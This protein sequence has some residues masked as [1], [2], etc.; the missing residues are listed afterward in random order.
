MVFAFDEDFIRRELLFRCWDHVS[1]EFCGIWVPKY[2]GSTEF[3]KER[4]L[5]MVQRF[6]ETNRR[7]KIISSEL[8]ERLFPLVDR[9][10]INIVVG[11]L[12]LLDFF[13]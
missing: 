7:W 1:K 6:R 12:H 2:E 9:N 13:N 8:T 11:Y 3:P 5:K 10:V 4:Y